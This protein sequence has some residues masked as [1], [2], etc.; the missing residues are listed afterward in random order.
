M[1]GKKSLFLTFF[2][3]GR[4]QRMQMNVILVPAFHLPQGPGY[5]FQSL[6]A[7]VLQFLP[8][9]FLSQCIPV[10]PENMPN[11]FFELFRLLSGTCARI[12]FLYFCLFKNAVQRTRGEVISRVSG[13]SDPAGFCTIFIL[14][15]T[16]FYCYKVLSIAF[17]NFNDVP[18]FQEDTFVTV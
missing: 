10:D 16:P 7:S 1:V 13:N 18:D 3:S 9:F 5:A 14:A 4:Q 2:T 15:M 12:S 6:R 17:D 11:S 8:V